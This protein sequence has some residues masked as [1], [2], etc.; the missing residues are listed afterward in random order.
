MSR[1]LAREEAFKLLY[2]IDIHKGVKDE[3]MDVFYDIKEINDK[4]KQYIEDIVLGTL[5]DMEHINKLIEENAIGW[6]INRISKVNL[7]IL[8]LAIYEMLRRDDI[9]LNV[10]INE[11]IEI[12]KTYESEKSG[13]FINGI[14]GNILKQ[15]QRK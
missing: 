7:A 4:D 2:Q 12:A 8:R 9:P 3:V 11:A 10:S 13:S 6:K 1:R 15:L 14:L 5:N